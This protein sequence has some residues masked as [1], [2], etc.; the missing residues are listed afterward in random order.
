[1][2]S[3]GFHFIYLIFIYDFFKIIGNECHESV[4]CP[5]HSAV[6]SSER[7]PWNGRNLM[8]WKKCGT[9]Q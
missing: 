7:V 3:F 9:K 4:Y 5:S 6:S 1:M 8:D 2:R